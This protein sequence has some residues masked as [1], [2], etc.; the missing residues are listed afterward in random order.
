MQNVVVVIVDVGCELVGRLSCCELVRVFL[1]VLVLDRL[2]VRLHRVGEK[3]YD[4]VVLG[5]RVVLSLT[6]FVAHVVLRRELVGCFVCEHCQIEH[7][8]E[9]VLR[10]HTGRVAVIVGEVRSRVGRCLYD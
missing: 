9:H 10:R 7:G 8:A 5:I 3:V 1:N 2:A 6:L 4:C